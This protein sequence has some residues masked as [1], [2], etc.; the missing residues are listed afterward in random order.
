[1]IYWRS[2][3][4]LVVKALRGGGLGG[5]TSLWALTRNDIE[6]TPIQIHQ[7]LISML[8]D[9]YNNFSWLGILI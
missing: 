9:L 2:W 4:V 7:C 3:E 6:R 8:D 5:F 1:M